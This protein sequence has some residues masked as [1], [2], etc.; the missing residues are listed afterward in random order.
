MNLKNHSNAF[1]LVKSNN[2][3]TKKFS[4]SDLEKACRKKHKASVIPYKIDSLM[5]SAAKSSGGESQLKSLDASVKICARKYNECK[6]SADRLEEQV[7]KKQDELSEL[8]REKVALD[9][10]IV[11][12]NNE[13][14][15]I[16]NLNIEIR[17]SKVESDKK[18]H[19]RLKLNHMHVREMNL[20][21]AMDARINDLSNSFAKT[22][23]EKNQCQTM[24]GELESSLTSISQSYDNLERE[25]ELERSKREQDL[26]SKQMEA[27]HAEKIEAWRND[28]EVTRKDFE[29]E[30]NK[31]LQ[32]EK[33]CKLLRIQELE[34]DL[35]SLSKRSDVHK[36]GQGSCEDIFLH[37]KRAT[38]ANSIH[39]VVEKFVLHKDENN[40]LSKEKTVAEDRL[41]SIKSSLQKLLVEYD[42]LKSIGDE[43]GDLS[44]VTLRDLR[45]VLEREKNENKVLKS[46][47]EQIRAIVVRLRQGAIG[48][49]QRLFPYKSIFIDDDEHIP[50]PT[51]SEISTDDISEM[52]TIIHEIIGRMVHE[53]G[54][55]DQIEKTE[56]TS[57]PVARRE[58]VIK[59]ENPNLG[60]NNCR[61]QARK[62]K[63]H[64]NTVE[65]IDE[66]DDNDSDIVSRKA[67]KLL[68]SAK[69]PD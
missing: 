59:L 26:A 61:I 41:D 63:T 30:I 45:S 11:G 6:S 33:D 47:S 57:Y 13:A 28:Q 36:V 39:E 48:L 38:G 2:I 69:K 49:Y 54:G 23:Y 22:E 67:V 21:N 65:L 9:D 18:L 53:I 15:A 1:L 32:L 40:R 66:L 44:R 60:E 8:R 24:L 31:S 68:S 20:S 5:T 27:A 19:Y 37:I 35:S 3:D 7:K 14:K 64:S 55:I 50:S 25:V 34:R 16:E 12:S 58:S 43:E 52:L 29:Q 17:H 10:M 51:L 4:R 56:L 62:S 42:K 46:T